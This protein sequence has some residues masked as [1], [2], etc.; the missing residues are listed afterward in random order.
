M[1]KKK[2]KRKREK[3]EKIKCASILTFVNTKGCITFYFSTTRGVYFLG[4]FGWQ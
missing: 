3:R 2:I 1:S 4:R